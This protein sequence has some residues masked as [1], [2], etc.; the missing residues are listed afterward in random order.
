MTNFKASLLDAAEGEP[1]EVLILGGGGWDDDKVE[2]WGDYP[3]HVLLTWNEALPFIDREYDN[4]YGAPEC[5]ATYAWTPTRVLFVVQYDGS[6]CIS[7]VPRDPI[8]CKPDM[9]GG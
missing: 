6:T 3:Q 5:P 4:G 1:I 7:S 9:P 8:A 2:G